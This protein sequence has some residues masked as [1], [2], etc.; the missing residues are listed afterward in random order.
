MRT[1]QHAGC[2]LSDDSAQQMVATGA[3]HARQ[4]LMPV[5]YVEHLMPHVLPHNEA[6]MHPRLLEA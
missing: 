2:R 6:M 4:R 3:Q 1:R 5:G